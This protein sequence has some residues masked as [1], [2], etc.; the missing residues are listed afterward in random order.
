MSA[1]LANEPTLMV[2]VVHDELEACQEWEKNMKTT[3]KFRAL[4][5]RIHLELPGPPKVCKIMAF[6]AVIMVLGLLFYILLR[7]R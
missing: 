4:G 7:A 1:G 6:M 2:E 3:V 5:S